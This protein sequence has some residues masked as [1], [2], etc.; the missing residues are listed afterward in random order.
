[1]KWFITVRTPSLQSLW[2][3]AQAMTEPAKRMHWWPSIDML[4]III[5]LMVIGVGIWIAY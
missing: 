3:R 5:S 1:V 4:V 2:Q